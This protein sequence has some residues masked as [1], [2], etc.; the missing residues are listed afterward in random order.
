MRLYNNITGV[1][2]IWILFVLVISYFGFS[3]FPKKND[4]DIFINNFANWDGRHYLNIAEFG[5]G[6]SFQYAF[7]P[8]YPALIRFLT[9]FTHNFLASALIISIA[10]SYL[11][12]QLLYKLISLDFGMKLAREVILKM[13]FFPTSFF[14]V[15]AYSE[16]L[17]IFLSVA[18][19]YFFKK[20]RFC[21]AAVF[22][23]LSSL[24]RLVGV[25]V[26]IVLI[27]EVIRIGVNRKNWI[28]F[29]SPLGFLS[30]C[31]FLWQTT[32][33]P[34]YFI[35][36]ELHWQRAITFPWIGFWATIQNLAQPNFIIK[37]FHTLWDL[38]F[39]IFGVGMVIRGYRF[40][41]FRYAFFGFISLAIPLLT[42]SLTSI[43][44]FL[45]PI[46]PIFILTAKIKNSFFNFSYQLFSVMLLSLFIVLYING[47]W[48]S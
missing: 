32:G 24:T 40:L 12:L 30:Y 7:F 13:L 3:S 44:R 22:A 42:T 19:F 43:P 6:Q 5:Y 33:N 14:L 25:V 11:G 21:F 23:L 2:L 39:A 4:S 31:S 17:F 28:V 1:F 41:P 29:L 38:I 34:F 37:Y 48:I 46:F 35:V 8:L 9:Y 27:I 10:S 20:R 18:S 26:L 45:L 36:A 47:Y 15:T 16:G